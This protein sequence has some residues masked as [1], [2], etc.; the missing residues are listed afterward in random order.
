MSDISRPGDKN[1]KKEA[2]LDQLKQIL[3]AGLPEISS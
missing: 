2:V 3:E 1:F